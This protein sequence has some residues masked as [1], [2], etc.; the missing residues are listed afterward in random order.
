MVLRGMLL[1]AAG[2]LVGG[3]NAAEIGN[4][5]LNVHRLDE[6]QALWQVNLAQA[7]GILQRAGF[8]LAE[9][10]H[11]METLR[12]DAPGIVVSGFAEL[13][14]LWS[15]FYARF[16]SITNIPLWGTPALADA[17]RARHEAYHLFAA[18]LDTMD[19][20]IGHRL[21]EGEREWARGAASARGAMRAAG[22]LSE[23]QYWIS[24]LHNLRN[25][26]EGILLASPVLSAVTRE[27]IAGGQ[28]PTRSERMGGSPRRGFLSPVCSPVSNSAPH[29]PEHAGMMES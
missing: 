18:K 27:A 3:L 26:T 8:S 12:S 11:V 10:G 14:I 19:P 23:A 1:C 6:R 28:S 15:L 24:Y 20:G 7:P 17:R 4:L 9:Q 21:V 13:F 2:W 29:T 16:D 5:E 22:V 25:A